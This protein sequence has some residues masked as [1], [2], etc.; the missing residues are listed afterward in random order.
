MKLKDGEARHLAALL[1]ATA[2]PRS[3]AEALEI[4]AWIK[5][6]TGGR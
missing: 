5:R 2:R 3:E 4:Q 6:L 1:I